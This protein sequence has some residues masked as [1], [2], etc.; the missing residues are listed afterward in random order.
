MIFPGWR[1]KLQ[2]WHK[3]SESE[4]QAETQVS[5][6]GTDNLQHTH[7]SLFM[8]VY[9]YD[10]SSLSENNFSYRLITGSGCENDDRGIGLCVGMTSRF[11]E[12]MIMFVGIQYKFSQMCGIS[13][14]CGNWPSL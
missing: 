4:G 13:P 6:L 2:G 8:Q 9:S 1:L 3:K 11:I 10:V 7:V 14:V 12:K 5:F